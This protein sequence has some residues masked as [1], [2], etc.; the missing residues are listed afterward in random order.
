M[1]TAD[2]GDMFDKEDLELIQDALRF[3]AQGI[4]GENPNLTEHCYAV[5]GDIHA[6]LD[7]L[8]PEKYMR[9]IDAKGKIEFDDDNKSM[10]NGYWSTTIKYSPEWLDNF[11]V[12]D[13][14]KVFAESFFY[15]HVGD[16][17]ETVKEAM[18]KAQ[19][20]NKDATNE[21]IESWQ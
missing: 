17:Y 16:T 4:V 2:N 5:S 10:H 6:Y 18:N 7:S 15:Y 11:E 8:L 1:W 20:W 13:P 14:D 19:T 12:D 21:E 9:L 3:Y